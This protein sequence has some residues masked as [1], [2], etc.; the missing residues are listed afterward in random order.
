[1]AHL[2]AHMWC[3]RP[4][5]LYGDFAPLLLA[6]G[7]DVV[8]VTSNRADEARMVKL[9][10]DQWRVVECESDEVIKYTDDGESRIVE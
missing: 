10:D 1:M 5:N 6:D 8:M 7:R 2:L 9:V 4:T 3:L